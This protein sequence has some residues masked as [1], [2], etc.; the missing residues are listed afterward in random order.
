V[1]D[2]DRSGSELEEARQDGPDGRGARHEG[3]G[4]PGERGDERRDRDPRIHERLELA[5]NLPAA[6]LD[7]ADLGDAGIDR[8][9][10]RGL[11]VDDDEGHVGQRR[12]E[13]GEAGLGA[14]RALGH[15]HAPTLGDATDTTR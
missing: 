5:E 1:R 2:E 10:A 14:A 8:G 15:P 7:G 3:V 13:F 12:A 9:T 4:D 6:H 11:E